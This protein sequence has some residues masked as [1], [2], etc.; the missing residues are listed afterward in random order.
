MLRDGAFWQWFIRE[1][2]DKKNLT[3]IFWEVFSNR[4]YFSFV[5]H[6]RQSG[7]IPGLVVWDFFLR[8]YFFK[9]NFKFSA[10]LN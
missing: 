10:K 2:R 3:R 9:S 6:Y 8:L 7:R 4:F 1:G 5:N